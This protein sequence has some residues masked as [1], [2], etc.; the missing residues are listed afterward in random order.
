M[1]NNMKEKNDLNISLIKKLAIKC[2]MNQF[3]KG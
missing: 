2:T 3:T 1:I